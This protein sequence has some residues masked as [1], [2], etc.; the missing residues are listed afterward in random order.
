MTDY[1]QLGMPLDVFVQRMNQQKFEL[2]DGEIIAMTPTQRPHSDTAKRLYD[3]I[4]LFLVEHD[5]GE[6]YMETTYA[7]QDTSQWVTGARIPD[8]MFFERRR[9]DDYIA[10]RPTDD[11]APY[12]L[13]PDLVVEIISPTDKYSVV[14]QK[15][16][17][18][19]GD[20]VR[21]I[22]IIDPQTRTIDIYTADA[23]PQT[24]T[25]DDT[26]TGG[27]VLAGFEARV[28]VLFGRTKS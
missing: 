25:A 21:Q 10:E 23:P 6:I 1:T 5:L 17:A 20:G 9:Y 15:I 18:Y 28:E 2:I 22:W 14:R 12:L 7:L 24:L 11:N 27:T 16:S 19:L 8:L 3:R 13:I 4:L 26:L